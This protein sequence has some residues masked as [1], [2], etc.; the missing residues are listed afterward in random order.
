MVLEETEGIVLLM[1]FVLFLRAQSA[2]SGTE[3][4]T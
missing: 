4:V 1:Q 2:M 3:F